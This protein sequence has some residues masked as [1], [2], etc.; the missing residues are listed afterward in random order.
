MGCDFEFQIQVQVRGTWR[1]VLKWSAK[2]SCGGGPLSKAARVAANRFALWG[3]YGEDTHGTDS[4][5]ADTHGADTMPKPSSCELNEPDR[6]RAK[7]EVVPQSTDESEPDK[8]ESEEIAPRATPHRCLFYSLSDLSKVRSV[9]KIPDLEYEYCSEIL[10]DA[11]RLMPVLQECPPCQCVEGSWCLEDGPEIYS[12]AESRL[13]R[14]HVVEPWVI[15]LF[16]EKN[17]GLLICEFLFPRAAEDVRLVWFDDE[18]TAEIIRERM[19]TGHVSEDTCNI[20]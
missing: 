20:S 2:T 18:G 1:A 7:I 10:R 8:S 9:L 5:G 14:K 6:K 11:A 17:L 12:K 19:V 15:E 4:H 13:V 3:D 16:A